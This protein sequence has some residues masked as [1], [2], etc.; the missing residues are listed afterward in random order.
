MREAENWPYPIQ[1]YPSYDNMI[2]DQA[3]KPVGAKLDYILI[4]TPNHVH[5]VP[6][7]PS[8]PVLIAQAAPLVEV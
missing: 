3:K 2:A 8:Q 6:G 5:S 7:T 4:V 1:G